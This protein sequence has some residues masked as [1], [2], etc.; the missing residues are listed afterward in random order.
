MRVLSLRPRLAA[1]ARLASGCRCL[2]D[3]GT[4][5]GCLPV[6]FALRNP[7]VRL[8]ATDLRPGPLARA[9][10]TARENGVYDRI[11][12]VLCDGLAF[13]A[14]AV[15]DTVVIAGMGG[16]TIRAV[17]EPAAAVRARARLVLQPQSKI[18]ELCR[19]LPDAGL[20]LTDAVLAREGGRLYVA[21]S[22]GGGPGGVVY[23]EELLLR[24]H[25]PL[26]GAWLDAAIAK[27]RRAASGIGRSDGGDAE[28]VLSEL[29][30]LETIKKE[31]EPWLRLEKS[32]IT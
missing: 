6:Y 12:F 7:D 2:A 16:E 30:R 28:P 5:H 14:A 27:L 25:D 10:K 24:N 9:E 32:S 3:I 17:L 15:C 8:F 13:E 23:P 1:A 29:V 19:W 21:L 31:A 20:M 26:L 11:R 4:D 18:N 22:A